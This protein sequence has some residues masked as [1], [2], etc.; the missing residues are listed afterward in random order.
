MLPTPHSEDLAG[1]EDDYEALK[2]KFAVCEM[3]ILFSNDGIKDG[4]QFVNTE[5]LKRTT[6]AA[7][8]STT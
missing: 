7:R 2:E 3:R 6:W 1:E 4:Q 5:G 8:S